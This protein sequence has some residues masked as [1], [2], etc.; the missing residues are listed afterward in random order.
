[1][2]VNG[3]IAIAEQECAQWFVAFLLLAFMTGL[4]N[5]LLKIVAM[6]FKN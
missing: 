5:S 4:V 6:F 3:V 2:N 1:M